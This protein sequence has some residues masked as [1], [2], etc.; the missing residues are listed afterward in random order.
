MGYIAAHV[1]KEHVYSIGACFLQSFIERLHGFVVVGSIKTKLFKIFHL[2]IS[3]SKPWR[4][5]EEER[6]RGGGTRE[7]K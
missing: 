3:A 4:G 2:C 7:E 5:G 6:G 1:V